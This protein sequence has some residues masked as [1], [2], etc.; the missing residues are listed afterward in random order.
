MSAALCLTMALAGAH[1]CAPGTPV[2]GGYSYAAPYS[3]AP[4]YPAAGPSTFGY[5][6]PTYRAPHQSYRGQQTYQP[7]YPPQGGNG[8]AAAPQAGYGGSQ[9]GN[10][11]Q[12]TDRAR[13]EPALVTI[14]AGETVEWQNVSRHPHTVTADPSQA[15]DPA[16]VVLPQGAQPIHSGEIPPGQ[17]FTYRFQTPGIYFYVCLPHEERGMV[18]I[19]VVNPGRGQGGQG[20][21]GGAPPAPGAG[22]RADY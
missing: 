7:A 3:A 8:A 6:Q 17:R 18:G 12:M 10:V 5:G 14:N 4:S 19:V 11:V 1:D 15:A 13:F 2:Y 21:G 22:G 20:Y 9:R 16:H